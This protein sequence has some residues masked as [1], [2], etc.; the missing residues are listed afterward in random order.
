MIE[1]KAVIMGKRCLEQLDSMDCY[2]GDLRREVCIT[3]Y[4]LLAIEQA[5]KMWELEMANKV[6]ERAGHVE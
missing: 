1:H 2:E 4:I 6:L 3:N 5:K